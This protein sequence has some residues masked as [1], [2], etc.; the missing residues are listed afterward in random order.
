MNSSATA[1]LTV[2]SAV[3]LAMLA[4][5]IIEVIFQRYNFTAEDTV[6]VAAA[7]RGYALGLIFYSALKVIQPTSYAVDKKW[8]PMFVSLA[9]IAT[10]PLGDAQV[11]MAQVA[12]EG[13]EEPFVGSAILREHDDAGATV[14]AVLDAINR[15]LGAVI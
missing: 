3:G 15:R 7:L 5:P 8:V 6:G 11:A 2:P 1:L 14:K 13:D 12:L 10:T 4:E 9:A